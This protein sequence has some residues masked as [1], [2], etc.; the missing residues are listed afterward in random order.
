MKEVLNLELPKV[1]FDSNLV[2]LIMQLEVLRNDAITIENDLN[3]NI[4]TTINISPDLKN[5]SKNI[6]NLLLIK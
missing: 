6:E 1:D 3:V 4:F 2:Q 5:N